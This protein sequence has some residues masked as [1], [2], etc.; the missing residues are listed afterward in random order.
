MLG[1]SRSVHVRK[2]SIL[3][4]R[5]F[6]RLA[7]MTAAAAAAT[8]AMVAAAQRTPAPADCDTDIEI[9]QSPTRLHSV[10]AATANVELV[11]R[12][13]NRAA[14]AAC[15]WGP[16]ILA[17]VVVATSTFTPAPTARPA[18]IDCPLKV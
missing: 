14:S 3:L 18:P 8:L 11:W 12:V 17:R 2:T 7:G 10:T 6:L 13:R 1:N 5:R 15:K 9:L 4:R 16:T